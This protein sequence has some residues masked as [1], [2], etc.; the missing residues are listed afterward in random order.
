MY[1]LCIHLCDIF[2]TFSCNNDVERRKEMFIVKSN[3]EIGSHLKSLILDNYKSVRRFC[4]SYLDNIEGR[5]SKDPTEIR[6]LTNRFSQIIN[7]KKAIQ[8]YDL[9]ILSELLRVSCEEILTG[10]TIKVPLAHRR[11]NYNIAFSRNEA[12]WEDYLAR[13]DCIAAYADEFGKTVLDYAIEFKNYNF[14]KYL[15][16]KGY[17]TLV[18]EDQSWKNFLIL[19]P[20]QES[21]KDHIST[22][23]YR[24]SFMITNNSDFKS[25]R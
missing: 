7:G 13:E 4:I 25:Y 9:P 18:A 14:I 8:T 20:N 19:G 11:T 16:N 3:E 22:Q 15:I 5:D 6:N 1:S 2:I 12:D 21:A 17:I 10:G 23:H 24:M